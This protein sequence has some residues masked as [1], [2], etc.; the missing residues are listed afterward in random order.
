MRGFYKGNVIKYVTRYQN[1][2]GKEDLEKA[3]TYLERL[4]K[5]DD[6]ALYLDSEEVIFN[7]DGFIKIKGRSQYNHKKG[8]K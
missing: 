3:Q 1:K 4:K 5:L 6:K 7:G 8:G 2:N